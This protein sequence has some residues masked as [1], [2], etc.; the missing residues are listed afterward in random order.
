MSEDPTRMRAKLHSIAQSIR[1]PKICIL[2]HQ[3]HR[4]NTAVCQFCIALLP[5]FTQSCTHCA[6]PLFD[7]HYSLC[8]R[9]IKK[10]PAIDKTL[11]QYHFEEPL[12][13]LI[14][15]FKY[16]QQ[17]HLASF[18]ADLIVHAWQKEK[19]RPQCLIPVPL[20]PQKTRQRGFNQSLL[21]TKHVAKKT[22]V[23]YDLTVCK[24]IKNTVAQASLNSQ[25]RTKNLKGA[26]QINANTYEH[27]A[28]IDDLLTTGST[29]NELATLLKRAGV[30][31]VE[32][33]CCARAYNNR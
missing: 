7:P 6:C 21:L 13:S 29:A 11:I 1:L 31:T 33:W 22:Q 2:C 16:H 19:T 27:V 23:P 12:R 14:H 4:D 8:G 28:L 32:L 25:E 18:L 17:I 5:H 3:F 15:Q 26:F 30:K 9:C 10:K 20:H 24:K